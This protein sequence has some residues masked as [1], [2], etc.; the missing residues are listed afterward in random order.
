MIKHYLELDH[1][2]YKALSELDNLI[3]VL[4][5]EKI[6]IIKA[7]LQFMNPVKSVIIEVSGESYQTGSIIIPIVHCMGTKIQQINMETDLGKHFKTQIQIVIKKRFKHFESCSIS[8]IA[9]ILDPRFKKVHFKEPLAVSS[10]LNMINYL[11]K[12]QTEDQP[13]KCVTSD[14]ANDHKKE[15]NVGYS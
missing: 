7:L 4:T 5:Q 9:T 14:F 11:L 3:D 6:K 10:A 12:F 8:A 2:M 13:D 1:Y 15:K